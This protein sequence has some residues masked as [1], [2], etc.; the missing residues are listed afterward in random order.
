[1]GDRYSFT[2]DGLHNIRV[3]GVKPGE[4]WEALH[5][6]RRLVRHLD[7]KASALFGLTHTGRY[8]VV[9]VLESADEDNDWDVIAA[10]EMLQDEK[11]VFDRYTGRK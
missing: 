1:M 2:S 8:L 6:K 3:Y 11:A 4:V 5:S 9:F 10:R 7:A